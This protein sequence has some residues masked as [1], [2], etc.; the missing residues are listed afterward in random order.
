MSAHEIQVD[1][2]R[3]GLTVSQ[4][5]LG[6][7]PF[8]GMYEG[9]D[10]NVID[11]IV[12]TAL[13]HGI[14][15]FD[16]A[17]FYGHGSSERRLGRNLSPLDRR[18]FTIST[19]VGRVLHPGQFEG[20][21]IFHDLE[22]F[23]PVYDYSPD[24]IRKS[25]EHSLERTGLPSVDI[26]FIHDPDDHM[27]QAIAEAYPTLDAMRAEGLISSIGVGTNTTEVALRFVRETDID[28]VL[29]AGRYTVIDQDAAGEFLPE[30]VRRNV[31]IVAGGVFNSGVLVNPHPGATFNYAPTSAEILQRVRAVHE[32]IAAHGVSVES[33]GLQFPLRH[34]AVKTVVTGVR[35]T[36]ELEANIAAF[37]AT[38]PQEV[39]ADL[40]SAGLITPLE[41]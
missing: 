23:V 39:W 15:F 13:R 3:G 32:T 37:D 8:G 36:A 35:T 21:T 18:S 5:G 6:T 27:D 30:A 11:S 22:P 25:L 19:K 33:V 16:T 31:S 1:L 10:E 26:L 12:D 29:L 38:V 17:P 40:E 28:V 9:I 34:P 14:T 41:A 24:G 4:L 2:G 7:A 20:E